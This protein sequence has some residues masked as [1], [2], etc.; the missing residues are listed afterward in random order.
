MHDAANSR[1]NGGFRRS[2]G[3]S[4]G[5]AAA[6]WRSLRDAQPRRRGLCAL[7]ILALL[8]AGCAATSPRHD[9]RV[10]VIS[11]LNSSYGSTE[12]EPEVRRAVEM[13]VT[14]WKPDL[15]LAAGDLIAGQ[16]RELSDG[17]VRAMWH[18]FDSLV[19]AP[20]RNAG[21]PF[22]F[23]LGNHDASGYPAYQRDRELA[24]SHWRTPDRRT[25]VAFADSANF[26]VY[27]SFVEGDVFVVVWDASTG[28]T[29][30]DTT[31]ME[32]V[33]DALSSESARGAGFRMVLGHL[34]LYGI[35]EG[36]N[37][38]GEVLQDADSLRAMLERH[39]VDVYVSGHHHAYYPG[40]RGSIDLL[41]SGALGQGPRQ[42][43]GTA[44][45]AMKTLTLL[46]FDLR[47]DAVVYTT[48]HF[49]EDDMDVVEPS[50]L[51]RMIVGFNGYVVR[52]DLPDSS[53]V[54]RS[55]VD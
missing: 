22:G 54:Q 40:R 42:L 26:P 37:K 32:W 4:R 38:P 30:A 45:P 51:P 14:E 43:I 25:N 28:G 21:I 35:A 16:K 31:M 29:A 3:L 39:N 1:P 34:P 52:R 47:E 18:A 41:Y 5:V 50:R 9:L 44:L 48:Y 33:Q 36:R 15:V 8:A 13:I 46:D 20:L 11:D 23:T 27:Y 12:Y 19:A 7:L 49:E 53:R 2:Y 17:E 10:A 55:R 6:A 24:L